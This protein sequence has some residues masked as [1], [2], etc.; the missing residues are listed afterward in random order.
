MATDMDKELTNAIQVCNNLSRDARAEGDLPTMYKA[1]HAWHILVAARDD[2]DK[3]HKS[4]A[5]AN[6]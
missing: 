1:N 5:S 4:L 2:R 3:R 6:Q